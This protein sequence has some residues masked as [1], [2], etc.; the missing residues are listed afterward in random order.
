MYVCAWGGLLTLGMRNT[1]S[2]QHP[3]SSLDCPAIL[4]LE[5]QSVGNKS[6]VALLQGG[7][8]NL[9]TQHQHHDYSEADCQRPPSGWW[10]NS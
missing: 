5:F 2:G 8:V 6:A 7:P 10:P 3:A 9:L 4:I 1:W